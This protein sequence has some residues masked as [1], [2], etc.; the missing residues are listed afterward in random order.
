M[1]TTSPTAVAGQRRLARDPPDG[2][3]PFAGSPLDT[4]ATVALHRQVYGRIRTLILS[5]QVAAGSRLPSTRALAASLNVSRNTVLAAFEQLRGE[6]Y[7]EGRHGSGTYVAPAV[8]DELL[9]PRVAASS[10]PGQSRAQQRRLSDRGTLIASTVRTPLP[11]LGPGP[12][13]RQSF[14]I[15]LPDLDSFPQAQWARHLAQCWRR[16]APGLMR[17]NHPAGYR[18]LREAIAARLATTRGVRCDADQV[19]IVAGSQQALAFAG[20][21]LLDPGDPVWMEEPGYIGAR[22]WPGTHE[23]ATRGRRSSSGTAGA[24]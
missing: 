23:A 13:E 3:T 21:M 22:Y 2:V 16:S 14:T 5:G 7:L 6:G 10:A 12:G 19:V 24:T 9:R 11:A 15:G 17:Y 8:P 4:S 1:G 18:P 20:R